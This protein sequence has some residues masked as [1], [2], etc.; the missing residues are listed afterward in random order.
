[1][2]TKVVLKRDKIERYK[3]R[4]ER[5]VDLLIV[6][7][8]IYTNCLLQ[9]QPKMVLMQ[10]SQTRST[11]QQSRGSE[12]SIATDISQHDYKRLRVSQQAYI[13]TEPNWLPNTNKCYPNPSNERR[14]HIYQRRRFPTHSW[15][16]AFGSILCEIKIN[17]SLQS[18]SESKKSQYQLYVSYRMPPWMLNRM[19][20]LRA[21][22]LRD[23]WAFKIST[24]NIIPPASLLFWYANAEDNDDISGIK[25]LFEQRVASPFDRNEYGYTA[26]HYAAWRGN[27][28]ICKF[29]LA[30][31][32]DPQAIAQDNN[33]PLLELSCA[34]R[35]NH[36]ARMEVL[37]L[38]SKNALLDPRNFTEWIGSEEGFCVLQRA[39]ETYAEREQI[40]RLDIAFAQLQGLQCTPSH[41]RKAFGQKNLDSRLCQYRN[42]FDD[43]T[44]IH[45]LRVRLSI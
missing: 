6:S 1:M 36:K 5:A 2:A 27:Y 35:G 12:G 30:Q 21:R 33:T 9:A 42:A 15:L 37:R 16:Q 40:E 14:L 23:G 32:A 28:N 29:L 39:D 43:R 22:S 44:F 11:S 26:L 19:W 18:G 38:F 41:I 31:G 3:E 34:D 25:T 10:I 13:N 24:Y 7:S 45:C 8:Q 20:E 17:Y 4:L